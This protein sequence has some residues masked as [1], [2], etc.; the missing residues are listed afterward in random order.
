[1]CTCACTCTCTCMC[2]RE[3]RRLRTYRAPFE[4]VTFDLVVEEVAGHRRWVFCSGRMPPNSCGMGRA[5]GCELATAKRRS[6]RIRSGPPSWLM[7][8]YLPF[9]PLKPSSTFLRFMVCIARGRFLRPSQRFSRPRCFCVVHGQQIGALRGAEDKGHNP[10][11]KMEA[12]TR[13]CASGWLRSFGEP[14]NS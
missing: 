11:D 5:H 12:R 13:P 7:P 1:V 14:C 10:G 9:F 4:M 8:N 3:R 6:G 2:G